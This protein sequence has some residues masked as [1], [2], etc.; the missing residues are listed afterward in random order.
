MIVLLKN[1]YG[2]KIA[3]TFLTTMVI[4]EMGYDYSLKCNCELSSFCCLRGVERVYN[5]SK[6]FFVFKIIFGW[7]HSLKIHMFCCE[8][9]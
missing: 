3:R 6:H 5:D 9:L 8:M 7:R 4:I 2:L 1:N